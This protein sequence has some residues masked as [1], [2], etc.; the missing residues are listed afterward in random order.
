[1]IEPDLF[2]A[3]LNEAAVGCAALWAF[4]PIAPTA[5]DTG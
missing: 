1:M 2:E 5:R 3:G 4:K